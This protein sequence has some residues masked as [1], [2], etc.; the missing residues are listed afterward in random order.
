MKRK[1]KELKEEIQKLDARADNIE[2]SQ[3]EW[4]RRYNL[5]EQLEKLYEDEELIWQKQSGEQ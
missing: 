3:E 1:K 4:R 5:E 2:L